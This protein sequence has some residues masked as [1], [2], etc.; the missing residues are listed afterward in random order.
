ML[1]KIN[2]NV[3]SDIEMA[4][5]KYG[6]ETPEQ[7]EIYLF[8]VYSENTKNMMNRERRILNL[9]KWSELLAMNVEAQQKAKEGTESINNYLTDVY[10]LIF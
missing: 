1:S 2:V 6:A 5:K 4:A 9:T 7:Q 10:L 3:K 8:D